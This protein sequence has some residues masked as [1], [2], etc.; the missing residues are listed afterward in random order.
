MGG[1]NRVVLCTADVRIISNET[2]LISRSTRILPA[3]LSGD[4]ERSTKIV[5]LTPPEAF[6][7]RDEESQHG[8]ANKIRRP[9]SA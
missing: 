3:A 1:T 9:A 7:F 5:H 4:V 8:G 2:T 6:F